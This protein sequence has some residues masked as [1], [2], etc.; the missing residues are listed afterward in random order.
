[1]TKFLHERL[2]DPLTYF[3]SQGL[4][5]QG[6][7]HW[8]TTACQFHGGSDSM[9]IEVNSGAWKCMNCQI[10]GGDVLAFHMALHRLDF[11]QAAKD[12]KCW[13]GFATREKNQARQPRKFSPLSALQVLAFESS[14]VAVAAG[15]LSAGSKLSDLDIKRLLVAVRRINHIS[16]SYGKK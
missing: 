14:L 5:L 16:E 11:V 13:D 6:R 7:G 10:G 9:R 15:N 4:K 3:E 1:M 2:P 12:L 8:R